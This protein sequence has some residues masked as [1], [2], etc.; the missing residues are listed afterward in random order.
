MPAKGRIIGPHAYR[1]A[2]ERSGLCQELC[3]S[4][5]S[6][7]EF[8][9]APA[10][11]DPCA[12]GERGPSL[13]RDTDVE[14]G[15]VGESSPAVAGISDLARSR[16]V[17]GAILLSCTVAFH[18]LYRLRIPE[19]EDAVP[20]RSRLQKKHLPERHHLSSEARRNF[21][22][23]DLRIDQ[24]QDAPCLGRQPS[25]ASARPSRRDLSPE[26]VDAGE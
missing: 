8:F 19:I 7:V 3:I 17:H 23:W 21:F 4:R 14:G 6:L 9:F 18:R 1:L 5:K 22:A 10:G 15:V 20:W 26:G 25:P 12:T 11:L 24:V 2:S 16:R 13:L